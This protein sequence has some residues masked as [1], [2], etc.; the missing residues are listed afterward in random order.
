MHLQGHTLDVYYTAIGHTPESI[1]KVSL[2]LQKNWAAATWDSSRLED[3]LDPAEEYEGVRQPK[4]SSS[5]GIVSGP[6][7]QLRDPFVFEDTGKGLLHL[8]YSV[9]GEQGLGVA[10]KLL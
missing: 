6:A 7:H 3:V 1:K 2:D 10:T 8:L 4:T 9:A 5:C